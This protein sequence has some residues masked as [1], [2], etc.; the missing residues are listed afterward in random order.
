MHPYN[1]SLC[2]HKGKCTSF[3]FTLASPL[4]GLQDWTPEI[5]A[6]ARQLCLRSNQIG[7]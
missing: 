7:H 6:W 4:P 3:R 1:K 2:T 5:H